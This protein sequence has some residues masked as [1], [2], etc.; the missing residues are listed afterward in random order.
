MFAVATEARQQKGQNF[1]NHHTM[2]R[3]GKCGMAVHFSSFFACVS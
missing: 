3:A 2:E 1:S